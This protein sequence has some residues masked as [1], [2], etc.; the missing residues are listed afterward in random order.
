MLARGFA[1]RVFERVRAV[2]RLPEAYLPFLRSPPGFEI[3]FKEF[4]LIARTFLSPIRTGEG[5]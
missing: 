3:R 1:G 4:P 2:T 5:L